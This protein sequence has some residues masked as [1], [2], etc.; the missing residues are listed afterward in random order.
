MSSQAGGHGRT[1]R[2]TPTEKYA[3]TKIIRTQIGAALYDLKHSSYERTTSELYMAVDHTKEKG[4][5][6][7][8]YKDAREGKNAYAGP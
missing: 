7:T 8:A 6:A 3:I 1:A 5:A 2:K 4:L